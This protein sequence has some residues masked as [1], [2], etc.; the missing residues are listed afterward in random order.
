VTLVEGI[1][2]GAYGRTSAEGNAALERLA[3]SE[4]ILLNAVYTAKAFAGLLGEATRLG[5][6]EPAVFLHTGGVPALF[7]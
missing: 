2:V 3:R 5:S 7:A 4:G 6:D 1:H